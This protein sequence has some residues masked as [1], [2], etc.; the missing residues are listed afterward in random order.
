MQEIKIMNL[1][2]LLF[3]MF[4]LSGISANL[5]AQTKPTPTPA[6]KPTPSVLPTQILQIVPRNKL[7]QVTGIPPQTLAELDSAGKLMQDGKYEESI[8]AQTNIIKAHPTIMIAYNNRGYSYMQLGKFDLAIEDFNVALKLSPTSMTYNNRSQ[9]FLK[10]GDS[11][12]ALAD[13]F[14]A[15]ELNPQ[16]SLPYSNRAAVY[17]GMGKYESALADLDKAISITPKEA[18]YF[19]NR[20]FA[21]YNLKLYEQA[22]K[23]CNDAIQMNPQGSLAYSTRAALYLQ[24]S[25]FESALA[26][27]DTA[28]K[29]D[30]GDLASNYLNRGFALVNLNRPEEAAESLTKSIAARP[31]VLAY[32][33][34]AKVYE[35]LNQPDAELAD[36]GKA[37]ELEPKNAV[38]YN[39]RGIFYLRRADRAAA[40]ADFTKAIELN[41]K[42]A[43]S[44]R[45]RAFLYKQ[46]G[47]TEKA[48]ADEKTAAT[49]DAVAA[50]VK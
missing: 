42:I 28:I 23:D 19:T 25:S 39:N 2:K 14:K 47:E 3:L 44:Y 17:I 40:L 15:I 34:R 18:V 46:T 20:C 6:S 32:L 37:I 5:Y 29:R 24:F 48:Q 30:G 38:I 10:K 49:L 21:K 27:Y 13:V 43:V 31:S 45:N 9:A 11:A 50:P 36:Y 4:A 8:A 22:L 12:K 1:T 35:K 7:V 16:S 33:Y 26:D 41:P